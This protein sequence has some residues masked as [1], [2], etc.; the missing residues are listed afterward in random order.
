MWEAT[1]STPKQTTWTCPT[2]RRGS[3][4]SHMQKRFRHVAVKYGGNAFTSTSV[5]QLC[6]FLR[7]MNYYGWFTVSQTWLSGSNYWNTCSIR[8]RLGSGSRSITRSL[9]TLSQSC[10][11]PRFFPI[12][13]CPL[14]CPLQ[15]MT[16]YGVGAMISQQYPKPCQCWWVSSSSHAGSP[17]EEAS[18]DAA[19]YSI[20]GH[21]SHMTRLHPEQGVT[22]HTARMSHSCARSD[23]TF[24]ISPT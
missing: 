22:L 7:P 13:N 24:R 2:C 12:T 16:L 3:D 14:F 10:L 1:Q 18:S 15:L 19:C 4:M 23:A 20:W 17:R 5:P 6:S 8:E 11:H 21:Y 9:T